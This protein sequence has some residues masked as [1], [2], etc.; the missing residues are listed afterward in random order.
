MVVWLLVI[1]EDKPS[2]SMFG[3]LT[4]RD[5]EKTPLAKYANH[6][7]KLKWRFTL[8]IVFAFQSASEQVLHHPCRVLPALH[9]FL[10]NCY[11]SNSKGEAQRWPNAQQMSMTSPIAEK[12]LR[13]C[14]FSHRNAVRGALIG[15][16]IAFGPLSIFN[17]DDIL[18]FRIFLSGNKAMRC[19]RKTLVID[20]VCVMMRNIKNNIMAREQPDSRC[21]VFNPRENLL[22]RYLKHSND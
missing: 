20:D 5:W 18:G 3:A 14:D 16:C 17:L 2:A 7:W 13:R 12:I 15:V 21:F 19:S 1:D 11:E 4:F 10:R 22:T 9:I 8:H 6:V